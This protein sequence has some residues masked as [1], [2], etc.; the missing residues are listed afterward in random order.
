MVT[1]VPGV[2]PACELLSRDGVDLVISDMKLGTGSGLDVLRAAQRA[3]AAGGGVDYRL[4]DAIRRGGGDARGAYDYICKPSTTRS[5]GSWCRRRW[6]SASL[7]QENTSAARARLLPGLEASRWAQR[8]D[9]ERVSLVEKGGAGAQHGAGDGESGTGRAGGA[10]HPTYGAIARRTRSSF[11]CAAL[12]EEHAGGSGC[13][14]HVKG[15]SPGGALQKD[16]GLLVSAGGDGDVGQWGDAARDTGEA[17]AG[18]A[19]AEGEAGGQRG[20]PLSGASHRGDQP[21]SWRRR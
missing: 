2:K 6:R 7:R 3:K 18:V 11:S 1:S 12:N 19:G 5:S 4:R 9:A 8:A 15:A 14:G 13:S 20:G 10:G 17:P 21:E 16:A